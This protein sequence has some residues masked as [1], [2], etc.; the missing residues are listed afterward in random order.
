MCTSRATADRLIDEVGLAQAG[1]RLKV[2][3]ILFTYRCSISCR[4]CLFGCATDRPDVVMT[5]PQC[6]DGLALLHETGRVV[7]IAGGEAMLYWETLAASLR[8]AHAEGSAPHFIET[9]GSFAVDDR[10]ARNR[11]EF[12]AAHSVRGLLSSA[13]PYH[14]EFVPPERF[15]RVRRLTREIFGEQNFW[16]PQGDD[17]EIRRFADIARDPQQLRQHVR[18]H[19]PVAVG[20]AH[21][22]LAPHLDAHPIDAPD[23]PQRGW[24]GDVQRSD[25]LGEFQAESLWELH[26]DPYGNLQTNCGMILGNTDRETP[27]ELLARGPEKAHRFV[28]TV[29]AKGP[30]GLAELARDEHRF[31]IP[32][33]V[34]QNCD[35][36]YQTRS[37]LRRFHPQVFGPEE[38]YSIAE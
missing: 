11:L 31:S 7:H 3:A 35:L 28:E 10:V 22:E 1:S 34:T 9:N 14:Q 15:L 5:P 27:A 32:E 20:T 29:C 30:L 4:H 25:C 8:L 17:E 2:A 19:P 36:C 18:R 6:A 16:G 23:L 13:D 38:I 37:F 12:L 24:Q 26:L 33:R 21:R